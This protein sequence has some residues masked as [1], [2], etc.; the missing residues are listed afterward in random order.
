MSS[1]NFKVQAVVVVAT[2]GVHNFFG[3]VDEAFTRVETDPNV[4]E[5]ELSDE[6]DE[7]E[8]KLHVLKI[9]RNVWDRFRDYLAQ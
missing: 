7:I 9:P 3:V 6:H 1:Y 2:M 4:A 5:M 8:A